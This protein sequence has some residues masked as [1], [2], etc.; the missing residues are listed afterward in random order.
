[1][2]V[3][4][5]HKD[6]RR[7]RSAMINLAPT[8]TGS[9]TR[10]RTHA[11]SGALAGSNATL[12]GTVTHIPLLPDPKDV[13]AGLVYGPGGAYIGTLTATGGGTVLLRRR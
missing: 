12:L 3:D 1:M 2:V 7:A 9:A 8:T 13:R 6:L 10:F 5:A 4:A 11:T